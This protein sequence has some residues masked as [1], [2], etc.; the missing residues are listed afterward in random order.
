MTDTKQT[1]K[2]ILELIEYIKKVVKEKFDVELA[3][4]IKIIGE[5]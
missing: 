4:E 5:K 1:A 3:T 2:D